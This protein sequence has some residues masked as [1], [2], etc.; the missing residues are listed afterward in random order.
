MS[1]ILKKGIDISTAIE[2]DPGHTNP[3]WYDIVFDFFVNKELPSSID[4]VESGARFIFYILIG[5]GGVVGLLFLAHYIYQ[6]II[7]WQ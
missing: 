3:A 6:L 7:S 4:T 5:T 2:E 1:N